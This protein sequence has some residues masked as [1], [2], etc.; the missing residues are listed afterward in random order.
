M[1]VPLAPYPTPT[2]PVT[3]PAANAN[4]VAHV[5]CGNCQMLLMYQYGARSVK[6]AVCNFVT[7][8]GVSMKSLL[9][10]NLSI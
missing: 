8:V 10:A 1:P 5:N 7:T 9:H 3:P 4:Q 6:C 2:V